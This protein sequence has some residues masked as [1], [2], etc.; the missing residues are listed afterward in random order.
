MSC[1]RRG[2]HP[3]C[4]SLFGDIFFGSDASIWQLD[5]I[6]G[7]FTMRF[8]NGDELTR[9][10]ALPESQDE[11]L[12]GWLTSEAAAHGLVLGH[13][14]RMTS[15]SH[16]CSAVPSRLWNLSVMDFVGAVNIAGQIHDQV[17][18]VRP[19][20]RSARSSSNTTGGR[21]RDYSLDRAA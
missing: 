2:K 4:T 3:L 18:E 9:A 7:S 10:L 6:D 13:H 21:L 20:R 12:I 1:F 8:A 15:P 5:I 19:P 16:W 11:V 17:R 14:G